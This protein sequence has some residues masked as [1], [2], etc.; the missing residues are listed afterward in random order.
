MRC[1]RGRVLEALN[2]RKSS[3]TVSTSIN[4]SKGHKDEPCKYFDIAA[5]RWWS[6][7]RAQSTAFRHTKQVLRPPPEP[8]ALIRHVD[9]FRVRC[10]P[11]TG[12]GK[13]RLNPQ[14]ATPQV[15][16]SEMI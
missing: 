14:F 16:P 6:S 10:N 15:R 13:R 7:V 2:L 4:V 1:Y 5:S 12:V 8:A 3:G 11:P 9:F